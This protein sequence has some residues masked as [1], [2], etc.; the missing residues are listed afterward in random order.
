M[1]TIWKRLLVGSF[2]LAAMM[3]ADAWAISKAEAQA[4]HVRLADEMSKLAKRGA[5]RGV[6]RSYRAMLELQRKDVVL[7]Y[8][9]HF[10]AAQKIPDHF[11]G[12]FKLFIFLEKV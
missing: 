9:D 7:Q 4:E 1:K 11:W 10:L 3:P 8:A 2:L 12:R 6:D 5:W